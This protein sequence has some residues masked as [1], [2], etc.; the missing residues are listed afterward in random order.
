[1]ESDCIVTKKVVTKRA[2]G[3]FGCRGVPLGQRAEQPGVRNTFYRFRILRSDL[4]NRLV[5]RSCITFPVHFDLR[6]G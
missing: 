1:M 6:N 3:G 4:L 2:E 5:Q